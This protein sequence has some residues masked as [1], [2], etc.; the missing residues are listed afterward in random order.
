[1]FVTFRHILEIV[2]GV[3]KEE[4]EELSNTLY[5]NT[6]KLFFPDECH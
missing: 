6:T 5:Q 1:M 3:K 4:M 2:A